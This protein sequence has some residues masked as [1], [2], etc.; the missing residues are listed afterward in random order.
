MKKNFCIINTLELIS[1]KKRNKQYNEV[2]KRKI[3]PEL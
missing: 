1:V 3:T 2:Q